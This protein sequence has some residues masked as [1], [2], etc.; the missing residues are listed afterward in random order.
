MTLPAGRGSGQLAV[1]DVNHDGR[2]DIITGN[3][4]SGDVTVLLAR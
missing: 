1:V 3:Y 4:D 2:A